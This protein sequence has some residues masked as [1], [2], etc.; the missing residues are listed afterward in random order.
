MK[1]RLLF[2]ALSI[3]TLSACNNRI[4]TNS[5]FLKQH[6]ITNKKVAILPAQVILTGKIPKGVDNAQIAQQV[7]SESK[8]YQDLFYA[9]FLA[10]ATS[11]KN[12][13]YGVSF[14][15]PSEINSLLTKNGIDV[16]NIGDVS[17]EE[18]A[19]ITGADLVLFATVKKNR[20]MS[21]G[22]ALGIDI[23]ENV[24]QAIFDPKGENIQTTGATKTYQ[25]GF[26]I[27]LIDGETGTTVH[28][29]SDF[30]EAD[31]QQN[32]DRVIKRNYARAVRKS[33]VFVQK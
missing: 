28:K 19:S 20:L 30:R 3:A 25:I 22:A 7:K 13:K 12:G 24:L 27:H 5:A 32:P 21:N 29:L 17:V 26:D 33:V 4:Y 10:K 31:W 6:D 15:E 1:I 18:L 16:K 9:E 11:E 23:A 14:I 8:F 2:L